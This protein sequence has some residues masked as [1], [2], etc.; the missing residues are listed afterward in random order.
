MS[1][2]GNDTEIVTAEGRKLSYREMNPGEI[3]DFLLACGSEGARNE[4][5]LNAAQAWCSVRA[6]DGI[7][8][9]FPSSRNGIRDLV[10]Q[11]GADGIDA[12]ERHLQVD[13]EDQVH[14]IKN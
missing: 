1:Q 12:I 8:V 3:L 10:N 13:D 11:I 6:I 9:P 5:Y 7:P 14:D 4:A 2:A